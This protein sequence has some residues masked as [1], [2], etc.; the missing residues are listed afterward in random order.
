MIF[1][2]KGANK[3]ARKLLF[4]DLVNTNYI[5]FSNITMTSYQHSWINFL[6]LIK[7]YIP[8]IRD[9]HQTDTQLNLKN[10][11]WQIFYR[12]VDLGFRIRQSLW[13]SDFLS[14]FPES[15]AQDS[16]FHKENSPRFRISRATRSRIPES[17]LPFTGYNRGITN[18]FH[19]YFFMRHRLFIEWQAWVEFELSLS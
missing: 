2:V 10:K 18:L 14:C 13:D 17:R 15:K 5:Y 11:L 16:R 3:N 12:S 6:K 4:T 19:A 8:T 7:V 9:Q 1:Q